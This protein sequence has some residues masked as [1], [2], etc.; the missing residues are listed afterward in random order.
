MRLQPALFPA[1]LPLGAVCFYWTSG[2]ETSPAD[3]R[4]NF[5]PSQ[6]SSI[7]QEAHGML[8]NAALPSSISQDSLISLQLIAFNEI[9]EV[10]FFTELLFN[11]TNNVDGYELSDDN[12]ESIIESIL[13]IQNQEELHALQA[14]QLLEYFGTNPIQPCNYSFPVSN[15]REAIWHASLFT[16]VNLGTMQDVTRIF[17]DSG[18]TSLIQ[19]LTS[20][21]GQE[22]EQEGFFRIIQQKLPSEVPFLTASVREFT[23]TALRSHVIPG[24]CSHLDAIHLKTFAPLNL[25]TTPVA[26]TEIIQFSYPNQ[27]YYGDLFAV[28]INQQ[29]LP[30]VEAIGVNDVKDYAVN[31]EALFPYNANEMNGLTIMT[32]TNSP[33]PFIDAREVAKSTLFGP[34]FIIVN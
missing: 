21:I 10:A 16:S 14:N 1:L 29:N 32:L 23:F 4:S 8:P 30:I 9:F 33:G 31:A 12:G 34:A 28:Y 27:T 18:D 19:V 25:I 22:G 17:A 2:T 7:E 20:I 3:R 11:L 5:S 24:S 26:E 15:L 6:I 13:T